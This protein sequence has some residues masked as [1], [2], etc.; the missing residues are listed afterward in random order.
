MTVGKMGFFIILDL[1]VRCHFLKWQWNIIF[2]K[3][4]LIWILLNVSLGLWNTRIWNKSQRKAPSRETINSLKVISTP[5]YIPLEKENKISPILPKYIFPE[6]NS[7]MLSFSIPTP[8]AMVW[9]GSLASSLPQHFCQPL[10]SAGVWYK[11]PSFS[12]LPSS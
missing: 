12:L 10:N 5:P 8:P 1:D 2:K 7:L 4:Q 11:L 9:F 3:S 6:R